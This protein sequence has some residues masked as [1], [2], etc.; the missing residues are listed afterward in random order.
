MICEQANH[1]M[2]FRMLPERKSILFNEI[3]LTDQKK[4]SEVGGGRWTG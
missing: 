2:L 4:V 3:D 1:F